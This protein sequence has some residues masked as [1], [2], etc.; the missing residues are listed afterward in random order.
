MRERIAKPKGGNMNKTTG[1]NK[2]LIAFIGL[3][4]IFSAFSVVI[5]IPGISTA[6][7]VIGEIS[8]SDWQ[9][10]GVVLDV[11]DLNELYR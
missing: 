9:K 7:E 6:S 10:Y 11:G 5:A 8:S 2:A 1:P 3:L 4:F